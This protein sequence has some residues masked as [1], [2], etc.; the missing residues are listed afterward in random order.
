MSGVATMDK[1]NTDNSRQES[2]WNYPEGHQL[3]QV[4]S[5]L[6]N[7][8]KLPH[9][10]HWVSHAL[11]GPGSFADK[12]VRFLVA[13]HG[14][15]YEQARL[16]PLPDSIPLLKKRAYALRPELRPYWEQ[17]DQEASEQSVTTNVCD[18]EKG[19]RSLENASSA[20][21]DASDES[22]GTTE[23]VCANELN[24]AIDGLDGFEDAD[25]VV[26]LRAGECAHQQC[27]MLA[28]LLERGGECTRFEMDQHFWPESED[29]RG[30]K[31]LWRLKSEIEVIFGNGWGLDVERKR[32]KPPN[33]LRTRMVRLV[34]PSNSDEIRTKSGP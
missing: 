28:F 22:S 26:R 24:A 20:V 25:L 1:G 23:T 19:I 4:A 27:E 29:G 32:T 5:H 31:A 14:M 21:P 6:M 33:N 7:V 9:I 3:R 8:S 30:D 17:L 34:R 12:V 11:P 16:F 2:V 13:E 15:S 18:E 10:I